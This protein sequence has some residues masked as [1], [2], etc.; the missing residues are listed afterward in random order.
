MDREPRLS[1][2]PLVQAAQ[3]CATAREVDAGLVDV[4]REFRRGVLQAAQD[5]FLNLGDRLVQC[6]GDFCV[7]HQNFL[8][9]AG[10]QVAA[11]YRVILGRII[12]FGEGTSH[13]DLDLFRRALTHED[14]VLAP[15]VLFDVLCEFVPGHADVLVGDDAA[16]RD[17]RDFRCAATDVDDH[18][19]HRLFHIDADAD[20]RGHG[21]VDQEHLF[22]PGM[23]RAVLDRALLD[24]GNAGG[25]AD[26]HPQGRIEQAPAALD[27]PDHALDHVLR[28][29]EIR[30]HAILEGAYRLDVLVGLAVHLLGLTPYGHGLVGGPVLRYDG[31]FIHHH[32]VFVVDDGVGGS[33]I[34]GDLLH[35]EVEQTHMLPN[36]RE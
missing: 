29:L 30:D 2:D 13:L 16:E 25:N 18:V 17:D 15:H 19:A 34:D 28:T 21:F 9:D 12:Q 24:L 7:A 35:E 5:G 36:L 3:Q 4:C 23:F 22:R 10:H 27:H 20:R 31:R 26:D 6:H 32:L 33:E 11:A 8:G 1:A 14:V